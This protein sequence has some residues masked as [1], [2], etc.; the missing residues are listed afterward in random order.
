MNFRER[1][2]QAR[3]VFDPVE[4]SEWGPVYIRHLTVDEKM[5]VW[6]IQDSDE[7]RKGLPI[8]VW[9]CLYALSDQ[10]GN[11]L[12][13]DDQIDQLHALSSVMLIRLGRK[14]AERNFMLSDQSIEEAKKN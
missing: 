2:E 5:R 1:F 6:E 7:L 13:A 4:T 14:A 9:I 12:Y 10:D 11:R 8:W 3:P